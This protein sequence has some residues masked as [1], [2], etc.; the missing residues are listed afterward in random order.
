[1][2]GIFGNDPEDRARERELDAYLDAEF[3]PMQCKECGH[4]FDTVDIDDDGLCKACAKAKRDEL[5]ED[6]E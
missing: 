4:T 2:A 3:A 6:E 1:M 5:R